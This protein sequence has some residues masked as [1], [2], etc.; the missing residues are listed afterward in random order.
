[1]KIN[2]RT[3]SEV[4]LPLIPAFLLPVFYYYFGLSKSY[5]L[6]FAG[7]GAELSAT[8][9]YYEWI[10]GI[11]L[12]TLVP[13]LSW[14]G[15]LGYKIKDLG[16]R[17]GPWKTAL[18]SFA[19]ML[20]FM[21]GYAWIAARFEEFHEIYPKFK[22]IGMAENFEITKYYALA[23]LFFFS[24]ELF[25]RGF[26]LQGLQ[27][28]LGPAAA[29]LISSMAAAPLFAAASILEGTVGL[30]V[31]FLFATIAVKTHSFYYGA[32]LS[33]IWMLSLDWMIIFGI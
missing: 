11:L 33:W 28:R 19:M 4:W 27:R 23:F 3:H 16:F 8:P 21:L 22:Y 13:I 14:T 1:M 29:I 25:F 12:F 20:V 17:F 30:M 6:F 24:R 26:V 5:E 7:Q 2:Q 31:N 15:L 10:F 18:S 32:I 9:V